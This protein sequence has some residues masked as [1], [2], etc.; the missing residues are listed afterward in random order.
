MLNPTHYKHHK[1]HKH[2]KYHK[3]YKHYK[4]HKFIGNPKKKIS[5]VA[6]WNPY[7]SVVFFPQGNRFFAPNFKE[8]IAIV[9]GGPHS[10]TNENETFI[11]WFASNLNLVSIEVLPAP[12]R[13]LRRLE[14]DTIPSLWMRK[15]LL[16]QWAS[17][18]MNHGCNLLRR[19]L[20]PFGNVFSSLLRI[21]LQ[22]VNIC[23]QYCMYI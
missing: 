14:L 9:E 13:S 3:Y 12:E 8:G 6:N 17:R 16:A 7:L 23:K 22:I 10:H 21:I 15:S 4:Y 2:Y 20:Q 1:Y 18:S 19:I 5:I 11:R